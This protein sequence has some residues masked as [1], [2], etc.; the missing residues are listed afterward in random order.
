MTQIEFY[1]T[2]DFERAA[3]FLCALAVVFAYLGWL[4]AHS[5]RYHAGRTHRIVRE[6]AADAEDPDDQGDDD[7]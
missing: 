2:I 5:A 1:E 6:A 3:L 7:G 4:Q